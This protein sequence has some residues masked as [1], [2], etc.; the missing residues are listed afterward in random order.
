MHLYIPRVPSQAVTWLFWCQVFVF[1]GHPV[2]LRETGFHS[3]CLWNKTLWFIICNSLW[4]AFT[5]FL[6]TGAAGLSAALCFIIQPLKCFAQ[7]QEHWMQQ[8]V[9]PPV[10]QQHGYTKHF[11]K[12]SAGIHKN[13]VTLLDQCIKLL[14]GSDC[15]S[16]Q[17]QSS[18]YHLLW[19]QWC[20]WHCL[21]HPHWVLDEQWG[22]LKT[23][24]PGP[25]GGD[26][27]ETGN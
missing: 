12:I 24:W 15:F 8:L 26:Q 11:T 1:E 9:D 16:S 19:L 5:S 2:L 14:W 17:G 21:W 20:F 7:T 6:P 3:H 18:G 27:L 22:G 4:F 25:E 23:A 10:P 13:Y